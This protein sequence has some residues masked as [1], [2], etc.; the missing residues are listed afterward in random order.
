MASATTMNTRNRIIQEDVA[1]ICRHDLPWEQFAGKTILVSGANG[2][3]PAYMVETLL[4]LNEA[5]SSNCC[6][7]ALVRNRNKAE[8]RFAHVLGRPDFRLHVQDVCSPVSLSERADF[9]IHAASQ[10]SPKYYGVDPVG[11]LSAN[12][13][14]THNLLAFA[15]QS[16]AEGFLFLSSGDVYGKVANPDV[17]I[18]EN[19][20]GSLDPTDVRSCYGESKRL[21]ETM[22][23]TW[24]H[25][26]GV[27]VKIVRPAHTYG[28]GLA[29]D[30]GRVFADFV[31]NIVRGEN[32]V[33][34]SAGTARRA[35]CYLTDATL[36][37][38]TVLLRGQNTHA[39]NV[40]NENCEV[41]VVEL[42]HL[43]VGLF[44]EKHLSVRFA[45]G[46]VQPGYIP[47]KIERGVL[48]TTKIRA[49]GWSPTTSLE[50]GFRKTVESF[51]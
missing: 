25:Q 38:F 14:G 5:R 19:D 17:P 21:G 10:A 39:Y 16:S 29:L 49:L 43:L 2:F 4:Y 34:K 28:P 12:T 40:T 46:S 37:F 3:L 35:F 24:H 42:A 47:S 32:I 20:Y 6:V 45:Q 23:V 27:P 18:T 33:L 48:D 15:K 13:L 31:A 30:D 50:A 41:S 8:K 7:I 22:C 36:A 26:F 44:P 11:T 9:I 51:A 1:A